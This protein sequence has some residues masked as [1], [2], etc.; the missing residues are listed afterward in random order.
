M[1]AKSVGE[2][3]ELRPE[4]VRHEA[5]GSEQ[6]H[7]ARAL[8]GASKRAKAIPPTKRHQEHQLPWI[9]DRIPDFD[10]GFPLA[11]FAETGANP[12]DR[13]FIVRERAGV[14]ALDSAH[15]VDQA[16]LIHARRA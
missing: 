7:R 16:G 13:L 2:R 11:H 4:R 12:I 9:I 15:L 5:L 10:I 6:P 8:A 3:E 1:V 14:P